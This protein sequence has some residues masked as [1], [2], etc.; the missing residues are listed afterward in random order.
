MF[1]GHVQNGMHGLGAE[2][3]SVQLDPSIVLFD[4]NYLL[5]LRGVPWERL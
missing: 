2:S 4:L 3:C 5:Y 1:N